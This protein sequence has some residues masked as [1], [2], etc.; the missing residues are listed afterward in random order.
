VE[1]MKHLLT[2][3]FR[4]ITGIKPTDTDFWAPFPHRALFCHCTNFLS[5]V[6]ALNDIPGSAMRIA[7]TKT[8]YI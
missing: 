7:Q 2:V 5:P 4:L 3:P 8:T 6:A 1:K